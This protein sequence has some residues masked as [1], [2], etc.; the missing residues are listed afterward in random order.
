[1][2]KN[3]QISQVHTD[4]QNKNAITDDYL[5]AVELSINNAQTEEQQIH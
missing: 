3:Q 5:K 1:M 4:S 2:I